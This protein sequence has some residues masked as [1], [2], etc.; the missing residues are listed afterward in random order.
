MD[1][2]LSMDMEYNSKRSRLSWER[3]P[4]KQGKEDNKKKLK[5]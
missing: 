3:L 5:K 2:A 4:D 1:N